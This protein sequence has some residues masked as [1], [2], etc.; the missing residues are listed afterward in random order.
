M[1]DNKC[2]CGI[3]QVE[4][5]EM[6]RNERKKNTTTRTDRQAETR[7]KIVQ[8]EFQ[9]WT[10]DKVDDCQL[11]E[12]WKKKE[13]RMIITLGGEEGNFFVKKYNPELDTMYRVDGLKNIDE[14][15]REMKRE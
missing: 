13:E 1:L 2:L 5:C 3:C 8:G 10:A 11:I 12:R 4:D 6:R 15:M 7:D 9:N 14:A